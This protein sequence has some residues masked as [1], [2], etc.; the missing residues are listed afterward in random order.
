LL[1]I[2][3]LCISYY[4]F[5]AT[6]EG[7]NFVSTALTDNDLKN[8]YLFG[9]KEQDSKTGFFEYH[10]RQYDSWL[11]RWH[12]VDPMAEMY[13]TQSPYHFAGN[14]PINN[15]EANG[16]YYYMSPF[17]SKNYGDEDD[18]FSF[19]IGDGFGSDGGGWDGWSG[20]GDAVGNTL[21]GTYVIGSVRT[22]AHVP[23]VY[24]DRNPLSGYTAPVVNEGT[25]NGWMPRDQAGGGSAPGHDYKIDK[26]GNITLIKEN[27]R[28][29]DRLFR[30]NE[31]GKIR[32]MQK[33]NVAP[34]ILKDGLN[35]MTT[36]E[37]INVN[38]TNPDGSPQPKLTDVEEFLIDYTDYIANKEMTGVYLV[39]PG[40]DDPYAVYIDEY[41]DHFQKTSTLSLDATK[42]NMK[43]VH[44]HYHTH[45]KG[46]YDPVNQ[47]RAGL[48]DKRMKQNQIDNYKRFIILTNDWSSPIEY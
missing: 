23:Y 12:V 4:P 6:Q 21:D 41:K 36:D 29:Q 25:G 2:S 42:I 47:T 15:Y 48:K 46:V 8:K 31:D 38:G 18:G 35:L 32:A 28:K 37:V 16:A 24:P 11:G 40:E 10:Y 22:V 30:V 3:N 43:H 26:D 33:I 14:N 17:D 1:N 7:L 20:G 44:T 45:P 19:D 9:G 39:A 13:G 27:G 5:G 34:G